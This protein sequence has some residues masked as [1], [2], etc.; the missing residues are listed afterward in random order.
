MSRSLASRKRRPISI[1]FGSR[2][3]I[4]AL[5]LLFEKSVPYFPIKKNIV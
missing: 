2:F 1:L 4:K 3:L 5:L